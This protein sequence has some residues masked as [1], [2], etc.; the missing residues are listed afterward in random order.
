MMSGCA[1]NEYQS[2]F[3]TVGGNEGEKCHYPTRLDTYGCGCGHNCRYCY[4]KEILS[5]HGR[6]N[7]EHPAVANLHKIE[8]QLQQLNK[9]CVLRLGGMTDCFQPLELECRT[10]LETIK[11]MNKYRIGYL[12]VT[13]SA[14][15]ADDEYMAVYDPELCHIQVSITTTDDKLSATYENASLPSERIKAIEKLARAGLDVQ[16]RLSP[17]INGYIDW[18]KFNAIK[19]KKV[20]VEFLRVSKKIRRWFPIDYSL[21]TVEQ[22]GYCQMPLEEKRKVLGL[23]K[24]KEISVCEDNTEHYN[25]WRDNFNPN[26]EDCCNLRHPEGVK[27]APAVKIEKRGRYSKFL[28]EFS[29]GCLVSGDNACEVFVDAIRHVGLELV[30]NAGFVYSGEPLVSSSRHTKYVSQSRETEEG[31]FVQ[32]HS[33]TNAKVRTLEKIFEALGIEARITLEAKG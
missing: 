6:W 31:F 11:L 33:S 24:G 28:V 7:P 17:Y 10:T 14:H 26:P 16:V 8:S 15:V 29:D 5:G 27:V 3:V 20:L 13:K 1:M 2:F 9:G 23:I 19:C 32:T 30:A 25:W 4:A 21:Y 12:I 22:D 18:E